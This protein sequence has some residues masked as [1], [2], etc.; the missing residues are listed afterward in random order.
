MKVNPHVHYFVIM[1]TE[2][3]ESNAL[4]LSSDSESMMTDMWVSYESCWLLLQT[5]TLSKLAQLNC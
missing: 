5:V 3:Q 4:P 1:A 2:K